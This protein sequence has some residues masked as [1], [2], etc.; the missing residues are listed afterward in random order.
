MWRKPTDADAKPSPKPF[1]VPASPVVVK[2]QAAAPLVVSEPA[3]TPAPQ[4]VPSPI[5]AA[6][7]TKAVIAQDNSTASTIGTGLKIRGELSGNA[8]LYI[9]GE[10][11]GKIVLAGSRVTVGPNGRVQADIEAREIIIQ[12]AVEGNLKARDSVRLGSSSRVQG[13]VQ[14]P[15]ISID[16]GAKL[17]GK[18]E[19]TRAN[20]SQTLSTAPQKTDAAPYG[21]V[22]VHSE[23]K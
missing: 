15:R 12:G 20:E 14:T 7:A 18:V 8:D 16:D 22:S 5:S 23:S 17:R 13:S 9:E 6:P 10:A 11:Q 21:T 2:P 3:P 1:E 19:M 4:P